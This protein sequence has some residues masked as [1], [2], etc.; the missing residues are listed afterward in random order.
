[1]NARMGRALLATVVTACA[2]AGLAGAARAPIESGRVVPGSGIH[3]V[4]LGMTRTQIVARLGKPLYE[5]ASG[6]MQYAKQSLFDVY[7]RQGRPRH[8]DLISAAGP[9]FCLSGGICSIQKGGLT[10]LVARYGPRLKVEIYPE[11]AD[12]PDYVLRG[13][14]G[15]RPV[16]TAISHSGKRI[17][18]FF[19][20]FADPGE[21][22][23]G[24]LPSSA[25]ATGLPVT[26]DVEAGLA[27]A[28]CGHIVD[29]TVC[30]DP[31]FHGP[32]LGRQCY[33][34]EAGGDAVCATYR[35]CHFAVAGAEWGV[36]TFW[37]P[38]SGAQGATA[39]F[40]RPSGGTWH[41]W[42]QLIVPRRLATLFRTFRC[43]I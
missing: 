43:P 10:R 2:L 37:L 40:R 39:W 27:S 36:A 7:V 33:P 12:M 41:A 1:M 17:L 20:A 4:T 16:N 31:L 34:L 32:L 30:A 28:Y 42:R 8:A 6:Y 38:Q 21:P 26:P 24:D 19:I 25:H 13:R 3:G 9:G 29:V 23:F 15:H 14:F 22:V 11:D 35:L 18:Q 5:N